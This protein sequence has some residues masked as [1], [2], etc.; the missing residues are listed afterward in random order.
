[1]SDVIIVAPHPD[2]EI[3]GCYEVLADITNTSIIIIYSGET[4][5][6]RRNETVQLRK[7]C[8]NVKVQLFQN[9]I[10]PSFL[11]K[12]NI[13]YFSDPI[14]E[15]HP[16]HRHWGSIGEGLAR[17]K[18]NVIF[19]ST[20]MNVP[21]IHEVRDKDLKEKLL[22]DVYPSEKSLWE[23]EKKFILFEARYKWIF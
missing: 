13:F 18:E 9:S 14:H 8:P 20:I 23:Y 22:N 16:L 1:M 12:Q 5:A 21:W 15:I 10:P 3:I 17:S 2:D 6:Q 4:E 11:N 7:F 19:Y